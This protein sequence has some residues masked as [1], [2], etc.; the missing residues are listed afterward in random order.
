MQVSHL[1]PPTFIITDA[2]SQKNFEESQV[3][4]FFNKIRLLIIYVF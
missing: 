1:H 2:F 4:L 3:F